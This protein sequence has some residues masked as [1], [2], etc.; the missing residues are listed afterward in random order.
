MSLSGRPPAACILGLARGADAAAAVVS[1]GVLVGWGRGTE[2]G[3]VA[4]A[5]LR[6]EVLGGAIEQ[7]A[8]AQAPQP[9][10]RFRAV[11][12]VAAVWKGRSYPA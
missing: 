9:L 8:F 1:R 4:E 3:A 6:A 12:G 2:Q 10:A 7:V 11:R 5:L